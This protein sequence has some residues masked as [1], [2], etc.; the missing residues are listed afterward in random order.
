MEFGFVTV[1][2]ISHRDVNLG[3]KYWKM[4]CSRLSCANNAALVNLYK[5]LSLVLKIDVYKCDWRHNEA[6][7]SL[8]GTTEHQ[9]FE[10]TK[11]NVLNFRTSYYIY[12]GC[13]HNEQLAYISRVPQ[14]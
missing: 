14:T 2:S 8:L 7:K 6:V 11:E 5:E 3:E 4:I 12:T 13:L 10:A 9:G 1:S